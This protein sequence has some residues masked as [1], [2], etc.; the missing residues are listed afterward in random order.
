MRVRKELSLR[1]KGI[2][3]FIRQFTRDNNLP[4]TV[5][6]IQASCRISSTSVVDYNL[7]LLQRDGYLNRRPDVARGIELVNESGRPASSLPRIPIVGYIAA[8]EPLPVFAAE[9]SS[10]EDGLGTVSPPPEMLRSNLPHYALRVKG[11][12]MVDAFVTDGDVLL[13]EKVAQAENG[14][15]VVAW[16]RL[17]EEATLKLFYHEGDRI[18]LQPANSQMEPIYSPASNVEVQGKVVGVIR[19]VG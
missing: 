6:D 18:R 10:A 11:L 16:L 8:G 9:R 5:R 7:R 1:Q 2:L 4:P 15:M 13:V 3:E 12:S 14:N 19:M 17:E